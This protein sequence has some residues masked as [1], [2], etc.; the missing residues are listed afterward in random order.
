MSEEKLSNF[1][2]SGQDWARL[3][4]SIPG[5]FVLKMPAYKNS[6]ARLAIEVNPVDASGN[7]TKKRG[8]ILRSLQE[9]EE[10]SKILG[11]EKISVLL[12]AVEK[13]NPPTKKA[14][15]GEDVVEV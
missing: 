7:P 5:V 10:Y 15:V 8:L 1:L 6:P 3:R 14:K 13:T 9:L 11:S 4:T 2:K 12:K